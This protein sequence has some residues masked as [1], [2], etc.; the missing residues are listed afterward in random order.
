M[1][2][3]IAYNDGQTQCM[4]RCTDIDLNMKTHVCSVVSNFKQMLDSICCGL[5]L[6]ADQAVP[7]SCGAG[8][9]L[10]G[11]RFGGDNSVLPTCL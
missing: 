3:T 10:L 6:L 2:N 8:L 11:A 7:L 5:W 9:A 1:H 4:H